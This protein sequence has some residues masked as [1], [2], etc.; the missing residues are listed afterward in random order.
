MEGH[1]DGDAGGFRHRAPVEAVGLHDGAV[2]VA[3]RAAELGGHRRF[4][5]KI[6][7]RTFREAF[8]RAQPH[9]NL[10]K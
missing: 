8:P 2:V 6:G 7:E 1:E 4:V 3:V 9:E 10:N 5:V